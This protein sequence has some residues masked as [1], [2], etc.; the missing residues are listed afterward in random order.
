MNFGDFTDD[1]RSMLREAG[2]PDAC[3]LQPHEFAHGAA[4]TLG[5]PRDHHAAIERWL[6]PRLAWW[7]QGI[8]V[9]HWVGLVS[10]RLGREL[11][12]RRAW[13]TVLRAAC[14]KFGKRQSLLVT[15]QGTTT[16]QFVC[17]CST[18][19]NTEVLQ[20]H[21]PAHQQTI[22]DWLR[23]I[24][25]TCMGNQHPNRY[26]VFL[27]PPLCESSPEKTDQEDI[28]FRDR[29]VVAFSDELIVL[30]ARSRGV[31][32]HLVSRRLADDAWSKPSIYVALGA[33]LTSTRLADQFMSAGA[34]GWIV[35]EPLQT[36]PAANRND[37]A[38]GDGT[39]APIIPMPVVE[40]WDF[41]SHFTRRR[42]G[43]WPDQSEG[44]F[45]DDLIL[46]REGADHSA[47]A[48]LRRILGQRRIAGTGEAIRGGFRVVSFTA[49]PL[50]E[51]QSR[52]VFRPHR[53]RWDFE[54][55]GLCIRRDWAVARSM[56]PV[57]YGDESLWNQL[58]PAEQ[59]FFQLSHTHNDE[60]QQV[61]DWTGEQE[62]R[63]LGD[64]EISDLPPD[65]GLV[66][67]PTWAEAESLA[68]VSRWPI[69][70][71][72]VSISSCQT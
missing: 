18:L 27:S 35:Q 2:W 5:V 46:E 69:V 64:V 13:F 26:E 24:A 63:H 48:S 66:F 34:V 4:L 30:H 53:G 54:P 61:I 9:G 21:E 47:L 11:D 50:P 19:F 33:G 68:S 6:G 3:A 71:V 40:T 58:S 67:V 14:G 31:I 49:V 72:N 22:V 32:D 8:P 7:P 20:I 12:L 56:K 10:S 23:Q 38:T 15:A 62:W 65:A 55:Y 51:M 36:T 52:R 28:P 37:D 16:A 43:P 41:L 59:P 60:P 29:A 42:Y 1:V 44:E 70:V 45:L 39:D 17:R 25:S 57:N